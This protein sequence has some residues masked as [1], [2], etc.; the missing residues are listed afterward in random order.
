MGFISFNGPIYIRLVRQFYANFRPVG[1]SYETSV[2]GKRFEVT[3]KALFQVF[4]ISRSGEGTS[5]G[6]VDPIFRKLLRPDRAYLKGEKRANQMTA[7][8]RVLHYIV[9][10]ILLPQTSPNYSRPI[11]IELRAMDAILNGNVLNWASI[12]L[13]KM[14]QAS[15]SKPKQ[16]LPYPMHVCRLL[17]HFDVQIPEIESVV[18]LPEKTHAFSDISLGKMDIEYYGNRCFYF[19]EAAILKAQGNVQQAADQ[20][21]V[22]S[23][24]LE[25]EQAAF[26]QQAGGSGSVPHDDPTDGI[27][28]DMPES[29]N[30]QFAQHRVYMKERLDIFD[31]MFAS[32]GHQAEEFR[33][34]MTGRADRI[35]GRLDALEIQAQEQRATLFD[36]RA[37][38]DLQHS[39]LHGRLDA[40]SDR[41]DASF[42][43]VRSDLSQILSALGRFQPYPRDDDQQPPSV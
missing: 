18:R 5:K 37:Q 8:N 13:A 28:F 32:M 9:S 12:I 42:G 3:P 19:D 30:S 43:H 1:N 36:M 35:D 39:A 7:D 33:N 31:G 2:L 29:W 14:N 41:M 34:I 10:H 11:Q 24:Q 15:D 21:G 40:H 27:N 4:G 17:Q 22:D 38:M 23:Q 6:E 25:E 26:D 20:L 16:H